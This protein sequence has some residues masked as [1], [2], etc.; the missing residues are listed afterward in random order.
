MVDQS[1]NVLNKDGLRYKDEFVRHKILDF[2]GD[3]SLLGMPII[4]HVVANRSGHTL[5][6]ALLET[7]ITQTHCWH[8]ST[9]PYEKSEATA[10]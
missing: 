4:G 1:S 3:L 10:G 2:I 9:W 5:N 6:H 8:T 7:L